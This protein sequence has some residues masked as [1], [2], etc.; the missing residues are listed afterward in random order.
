M[1]VYFI[2]DLHFGHNYIHNFGHRPWCNSS[3]EHDE[4]LVNRI[5]STVRKRDKLYILGDVAFSKDGVETFKRIK[6]CNKHVIWGNHDKVEHLVPFIEKH[7]GFCKYNKFWLSHCPMHPAELRGRRNIHG[8][9]HHNVLDDERY[10]CV[11]V[12]QCDGYPIPY[13]TIRQDTNG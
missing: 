2:A 11:C 12:D 7:D 1:S 13:E 5:N 6:C 8:H 4:V 10:I 9:V 3:E